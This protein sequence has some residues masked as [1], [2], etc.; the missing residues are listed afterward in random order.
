LVY[1]TRL[2]LDELIEKARIRAF[3][4]GL[5]DLLR[6]LGADALAQAELEERSAQAV[7]HTAGYGPGVQRT[8]PL[9]V[10]L[11]LARA[12]STLDARQEGTAH[13]NCRTL[14]W[15]MLG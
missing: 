3:A 4:L 14:R 2:S 5:T 10:E 13:I 12:L 7:P 11:D 6:A 9:V 1:M 15:Y 8:D